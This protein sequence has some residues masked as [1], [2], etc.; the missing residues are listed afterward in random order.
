MKREKGG[1]CE[2]GKWRGNEEGEGKAHPMENDNELQKTA[3]I[4]RREDALG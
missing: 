1:V 4:V 3:A 2:S